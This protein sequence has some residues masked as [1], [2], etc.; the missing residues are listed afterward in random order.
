MKEYI[1]LEEI[2]K[3]LNIDFSDDDAYLTDIVAVA[4]MSVE[5]AINSDLVSYE[6][7]D[8]TLNPMLKHAI[9]I[10]AG[11]FYANREPVSFATP[12]VIPYTLAYLIRPFK[13]YE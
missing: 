2:K 5:K 10:L 3:H 11:N 6:G 4:Q 13:K 9:K 7:E 8:G 1:T 12:N